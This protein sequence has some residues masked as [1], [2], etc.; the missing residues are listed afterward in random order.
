MIDRGAIVPGA[1]QF[2]GKLQSGKVDAWVPGTSLP[3]ACLL[4]SWSRQ[5]QQSPLLSRDRKYLLWVP[6]HSQ[7]LVMP[8]L[9]AHLH[10]IY[11][12]RNTSSDTAA[13]AVAWLR[14]REIWRTNER[15]GGFAKERLMQR[16]PES[17]YRGRG[18]S[19]AIGAFGPVQGI[20]QSCN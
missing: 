15:T 16:Y 19:G 14:D 17:K 7:A 3:A 9:N 1:F 13:Y 12:R 8:A 18:P 5:P 2:G 11:I 10:D 6:V 4:A 20:Y